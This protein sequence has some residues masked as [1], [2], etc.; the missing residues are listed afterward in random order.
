MSTGGVQVEYGPVSY[1][2]LLK[3]CKN[4]STKLMTNIFIFD[5]L[6]L[7]DWQIAVGNKGDVVTW[8]TKLNWKKHEQF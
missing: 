3:K 5:P 2:K 7:F 6:T 1:Q 4:L 8:C